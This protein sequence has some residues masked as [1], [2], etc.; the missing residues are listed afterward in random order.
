MKKYILVFAVLFIAAT[1]RSQTDKKKYPEPEFSNE[2]YYLKKDSI[3]TVIRLEKNSS[4]MGSKMKM[5]GLGGYESGYEM[6]GER[7]AVRFTRSNN[8]SFITSTGAGIRSSSKSD[9]IM[10]ANGIDP[11]MMSG[12]GGMMPGMNDPGSTITLYKVES[13]K[14]KRKIWMQKTGSAMPFASKKAQSSNKY[15]F[16]VKK[17]REGYWELVVDK[18]LPKGEYAFSSMI[19]SGMGNA[20]DMGTTLFAFGID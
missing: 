1:S 11:S 6:D 13:E 14:G 18:P 17:I 19:G 16:S 8:L 3:N 9:S 4:K 15:S 5:G 20:M 7:S 10:L 2:V 12:M